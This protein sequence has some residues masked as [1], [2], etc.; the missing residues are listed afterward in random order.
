MRGGKEHGPGNIP[1]TTVARNTV[2]RHKIVATPVKFFLLCL[3]GWG[4]MY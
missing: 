2:R 4:F 3:V 1:G